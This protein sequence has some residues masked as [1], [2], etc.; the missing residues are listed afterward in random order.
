MTEVWKP[1]PGMPLEA[2]NLG[3][4]RTLALKP[5]AITTTSLGY[6]RITLH[7]K[8]KTTTHPVGRLVCAAFNGPAP[9]GYECDHINRVRDDDRAENL[10]WLTVDDNRA[11]R[12]HPKGS[13]HWAA[14]I[15]EDTARQILAASGQTRE[16]ATLFGVSRRTVRNIK[17]RETWAHISSEGPAGA[18]NPPG[19]AR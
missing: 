19:I 1:V 16:I 14:K 12:V 8:G 18:N 15:T 5:K 2:S 17:N 10:R 6:R 9:E 13:A 3:N 7:L 4:V 11:R